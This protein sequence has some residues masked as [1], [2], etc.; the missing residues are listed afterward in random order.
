MVVLSESRISPHGL[1]L[2]NPLILLLQ[3]Q[4]LESQLC[5]VQAALTQALREKERLLLEVRKY[6]PK[7]T[8][9]TSLCLTSESVAAEECWWDWSGWMLGTSMTH[10]CLDIRHVSKEEESKMSVWITSFV[11][12]MKL[13]KK[14]PLITITGWGSWWTNIGTLTV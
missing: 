6:D 8:L 9:W 3:I 13:Q 12:F 5:E 10:S 4:P 2:T 14:K 7:F 11:L 1:L